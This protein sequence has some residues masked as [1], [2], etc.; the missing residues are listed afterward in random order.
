MHSGGI[1]LI[2]LPY[3]DIEIT[4]VFLQYKIQ[5]FILVKEGALTIPEYGCNIPN[6]GIGQ[7]LHI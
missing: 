2:S 7:V 5:T 3:I 4:R 6:R 1:G